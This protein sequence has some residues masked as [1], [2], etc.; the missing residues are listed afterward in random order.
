MRIIV[1]TIREEMKTMKLI[2]EGGYGQVF[3]VKRNDQ[4]Y[5]L[6]VVPNT[7][8]HTI[9]RERWAMQHIPS[10]HNVCV[11]FNC[12]TTDAH[13]SFLLELCEQDLYAVVANKGRL[14]QHTT[15]RYGEQMNNA[16]LWL[17]RHH[18]AHRD[19]K[20]ENWLLKQDV[21]KLSDFGLSCEWHPN[22]AQK[23]GCVGSLS[24][25]APEVLSG[26][27]YDPTVSDV[28][29]LGVCFFAM[30]AGFFPFHR[31]DGDDATFRKI[32]MTKNMCDAI[33][34]VYTRIIDFEL[35]VPLIDIMLQP[36]DSRIGL[37]RTQQVLSQIGISLATKAVDPTES[38]FDASMEVDPTE[39]L[40]KSS[41]HVWP[42]DE[43]DKKTTP[44]LL[45]R[46]FAFATQLTS[47]D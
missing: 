2:G 32:Y 7:L 29:S 43:S 1:V 26:L 14:D 35:F 40:F 44:P 31:A 46:L 33:F 22:D 39:P 12:E 18:L 47:G 20:L 45:S 17:N 34:K 3:R 37:L 30:L 16:L 42:H 9:V 5:A 10:H 11:V 41:P 21:I 23:R 15:F 19:V 13:V 27:S 28:W 38:S 36:R 24:Y 4:Y 8:S 25:C 6:K